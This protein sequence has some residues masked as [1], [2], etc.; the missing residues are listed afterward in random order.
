MPTVPTCIQP[1][2]HTLKN[3]D[4]QRFH[5]VCRKIQSV[6]SVSCCDKVFL[7]TYNIRQSVPDNSIV[8]PL[9]Y[10]TLA[11]LKKMEKQAI[12][13]L[14]DGSVMYELDLIKF[15]MSSITVLNYDK[16]CSFLL[17]GTKCGK[18]THCDI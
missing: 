6:L 10:T 17:I 4:K 7:V 2:Y 1:I 15:K 18:E 9:I 12:A 13:A 3:A 8:Q 5:D 11:K 16:R 14:N